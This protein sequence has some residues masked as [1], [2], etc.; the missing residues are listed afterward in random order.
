MKELVRCKSCGYIMEKGKL[1]GK[2]PA[3]GVLEKMFEPYTESISPRRKAILT[4]DL[5]PVLVHFPQGLIGAALVFSLLAMIIG[6]ATHER[7]VAAV[8][9]LSFAMPMAVLLAF[10]AGLLDGKVR[11]RRFTTPLLKTKMILGSL[12]FLFSCG[13]LL[14]AAMSPTLAGSALPAVAGLSIAGSVC[15]TYLG[16]IGTSLLNSKFPG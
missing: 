1:H 7:L 6:G 11:F 15:A 14:V 5:H 3:C 9:V 10:L 2:C 16:K 12:F 4:L 13:M 8:V